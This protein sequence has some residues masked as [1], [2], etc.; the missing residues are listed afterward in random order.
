M[1]TRIDWQVSALGFGC[2]RL[3]SKKKL[4]LKS[5]DEPEAI[6]TIRYAIDN[7]VNY[8]DT[9]Y[10]YHLGKSEILVGK[11][12]KDGYRDKVHLVTKLPMFFVRSTG[13]VE[14]LCTKQ[15][16]KL[17]TDYLDL[18]LFHSMNR[19]HMMKLKELNLI[20]EM[21]KL[22][23]RGLIKHIGFSFHDDFA[24][25]KEMIDLYDGWDAVQIQMNYM[26]TTNQATIQGLEYA[27]SKVLHGGLPERCQDPPQLLDHQPARREQ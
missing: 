11:A 24:T 12:L 10:N 7:G 15:L 23:E 1:G 21:E 18:Y 8:I 19:G 22:K 26:D 9:A 13:D 16:K 5:I 27:A 25:F 2:M 3:P 17:Q 14:K 20:P 4:F 6:K